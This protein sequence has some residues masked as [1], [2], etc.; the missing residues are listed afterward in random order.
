M[1]YERDKYKFIIAGTGGGLYDYVYHDANDLAY[2]TYDTGLVLKPFCK[3]LMRLHLSSR[4]NRIFPM[5]FRAVWGKLWVRQW[6]KK[7]EKMNLEDRNPCFILFADVIPFER[8]GLTKM[9]RK[10]FPRAKIVY[11][12]QDLVARDP[13]KLYLIQKK[14]ADCIFSFDC[15][16]AETYHLYEH[17]FPYSKWREHFYCGTPEYE[18]CFVGKAKD[19]LPQ[20]LE[21]YDYFTTQG[22]R[23]CFYVTGVPETEKQFADRIF[24]C[25]EMPYETYLDKISKAK[26]ILE[27]MQ[28]GGSGN[29]L[30]INEAVEFNKILITNNINVK[31]N[32]LYDPRYM[33]PYE[34]IDRI[35]C[36]CIR[37]IQNVCYEN[38][39]QMSIE[40]FLEDV[41]K[42][43]AANR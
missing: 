6:A 21:A 1:R 26:C 18:V 33:F 16:D 2:V 42:T 15:G 29:T 31:K 4:V 28:G 12:Y 10:T 5:P 14:T 40:T 36:D 38:R 19:R 39:E 7:L 22:L 35:E 20:I 32:P 17:N 11:F 30:R 43:L 25:D 34:K 3:A 41:A 27:I 24:Y 13:N 9:I 8:F 23:C 37:E